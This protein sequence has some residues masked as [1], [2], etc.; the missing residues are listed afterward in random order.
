MQSSAS[1]TAQVMTAVRERVQDLNDTGYFSA[2]PILV[3]IGNPARFHP[4]ADTA[5][6]LVTIWVYRLELD[7]LAILP[8][9]DS[10]QALRLHTL[11]TAF[12]QTGA[13]TAE[14]AGT[15]ELRILSHI[16]R[17]FLETPE[18]GPVRILNA[19]PIGPA[20]SLI[21]S[22]LMVEVRP[23]SMDVEDQNHLWAT[24]GDTPQR[25][26]VAYTFSFGIVTPS[27]PSG[28]GPP[29]IQALL[30]D[31]LDT[32][33]SAIGVRPE[34]PPVG[35]EVPVAL[36]VLAVQLGTPAAPNLSPEVTFTAG[37]GNVVLSLVAVTEVETD[38]V[39]TL[40]AWSGAAGWTDVT[41][42]LSATALT[43]LERQVLQDGTLITP[44]D[45]T[46]TDDGTAGLLRLS[47]TP[48]TD[49]DKLSL[50][51]VTI[52]MEAP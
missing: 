33:A 12:C 25:T 5:P 46:L 22:D 8:T 17:L 9:P 29:V 6:P 13:T 38:L 36:G 43:S 10:A 49:P 40:E 1:H 23:R 32:S 20:A 30:E 35:P 41:P 11:F 50:S 31:P 24:Q 15:F 39:L 27:R 4:R 28:D 44:T 52:T 34:L 48:T 7:N 2:T 45:V 3:E 14:S 16:I 42:R 19:L 26:S 37:A 18:L 51:R 21:T 47:A